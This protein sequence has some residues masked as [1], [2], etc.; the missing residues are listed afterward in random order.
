MSYS[1]SITADSKDEAG[2]KVEAEL[3]HVVLTQ[4]VHEHDR[5]AAQNVA[6]AFIDLLTEPQ[7]GEHF[8]V[9]VNGS[10]GRRSEGH[11]LH[12]NV[13]VA[14]SIQPKT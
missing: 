2:V 7:P 5:Q 12:A 3:A 13:A 9:S 14:A 10:L 1:F 8:V 4:P 11:F 6:E